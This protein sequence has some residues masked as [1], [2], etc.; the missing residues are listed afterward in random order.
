MVMTIAITPSLN[1]S[2]RPLPVARP[3][4]DGRLAGEAACLLR[5][6]GAPDATAESGRGPCAS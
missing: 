4:L 5:E 3:P 2:M 1:G 6:P